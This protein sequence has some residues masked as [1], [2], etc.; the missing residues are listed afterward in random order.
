MFSLINELRIFSKQSKR[1]Q[2]DIRKITPHSKGSWKVSLFIQFQLEKSGQ[3]E[4]EESIIEKQPRKYGKSMDLWKTLMVNFTLHHLELIH[5]KH[6]TTNSTKPELLRN[7]VI[8]VR[9]QYNLFVRT[10]GINQKS[11]FTVRKNFK[12]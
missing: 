4:E 3:R 7:I 6:Y 12:I 9:K 1:N 5:Y 10:D 8:I 2:E 11:V